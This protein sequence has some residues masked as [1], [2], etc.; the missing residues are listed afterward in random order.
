VVEV[1]V[2]A[3]THRLA[4]CSGPDDTPYEGGLF[5]ALLSFPK[6]YPLSPVRRFVKGKEEKEEK[7]KVVHL[8]APPAQ[9]ALRV[10][11]VPSKRCSLCGV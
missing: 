3:T 7:E 6:D 2:L 5:T 1:G 11:H 10:R 9:N 8:F 4:A